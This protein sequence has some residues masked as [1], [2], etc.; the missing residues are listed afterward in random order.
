[1]VDGV[2]PKQQTIGIPMLMW[3]TILNLVHEGH[4]GIEKSKRRARETL[5]WP[6]WVMISMT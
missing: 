1:M 5:Y 3:K 4:M 6:K 2:L